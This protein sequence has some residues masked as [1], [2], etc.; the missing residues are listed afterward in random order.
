M[1]YLKERLPDRL[2]TWNDIYIHLTKVLKTNNGNILNQVKPGL[3]LEHNL[4]LFFPMV[5]FV[6]NSSL[7]AHIFKGLG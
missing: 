4:F 2:I 5:Q 6:F 3:A 1:Q 7:N